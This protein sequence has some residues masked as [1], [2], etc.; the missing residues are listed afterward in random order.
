MYNLGFENCENEKLT[1]VG[2]IVKDCGTFLEMLPIHI[3]VLR[4]WDDDTWSRIKLDSVS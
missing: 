1:L 3:G 4:V 2:V